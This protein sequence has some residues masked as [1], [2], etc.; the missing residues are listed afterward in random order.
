MGDS[1]IDSVEDQPCPFLLSTSCSL[2]PLFIVQ[3]AL[4]PN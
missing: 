2:T 1:R 3:Q 4:S